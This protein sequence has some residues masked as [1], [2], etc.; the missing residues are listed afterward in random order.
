MYTDRMRQTEAILRRVLPTMTDVR[1]VYQGAGACQ[2]VI[3]LEVRFSDGQT[4]E[5]MIQDAT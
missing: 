3:S 4:V 5:V 2:E 1:D